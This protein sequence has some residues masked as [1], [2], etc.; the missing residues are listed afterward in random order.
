[1]TNPLYRAEIV[2]GKDEGICGA[3]KSNLQSVVLLSAVIFFTC[4][5]FTLRLSF[6]V[7]YLMD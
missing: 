7:L 6:D 3:I 1:M 4:V 2:G 5:I